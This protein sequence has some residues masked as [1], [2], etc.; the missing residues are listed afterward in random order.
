MGERR[1]TAGGSTG[2]TAWRS[3]DRGPAR[4]KSIYDG[5]ELHTAAE[6]HL[7]LPGS[8]DANT[9][10]EGD[11]DA[12]C[13]ASGECEYRSASGGNADPATTAFLSDTGALAGSCSTNARFY[14]RRG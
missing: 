3:R 13:N 12:A 5:S 1:G 10:S 14:A 8:S 4:P 2:Y 9:G 6:R 7:P 11:S